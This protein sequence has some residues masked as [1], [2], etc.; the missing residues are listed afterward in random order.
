MNLSPTATD[1]ELAKTWLKDL[2]STGLEGLVFKSGSG[3]YP[4]GQRS[5]LKLKTKRTFDAVCAAVIGPVTQP[6]AIIAGLPVDGDASDRGPLHRAFDAGRAR[7]GPS[8][9]PGSG[10]S[11]MAGKPH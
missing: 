1:M 7:V 3:P 8:P 10:R 9:P 11:P 4:A 2:S 6:Q 5:W